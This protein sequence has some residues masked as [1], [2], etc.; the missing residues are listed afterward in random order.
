MNDSDCELSAGSTITNF[1]GKRAQM[2]SQKLFVEQLQG[3]RVLSRY[4]TLK[5]M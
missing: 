5:N 4:R 3:K 2:H 1:F